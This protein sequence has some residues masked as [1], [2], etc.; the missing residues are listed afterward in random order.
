[1]LYLP[2][3]Y[4]RKPL[5]GKKAWV[6]ALRSGKYKQ[7]VGYLCFYGDYCCLGV[8]CEVQSRP[9]QPTETT[10]IF[11]YSE[12]ALSR[13]N[14]LYGKLGAEGD[15][16]DGVDWKGLSNLAKIN[17]DGATFSEIADIIDASWYDEQ[18][19]QP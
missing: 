2:D 16:P 17:D 18:E 12:M 8:L 13:A 3:G 1:M 14:P 7:G 9:N 4:K 19:E 5:P 15:L 6:A 11:D 10:I